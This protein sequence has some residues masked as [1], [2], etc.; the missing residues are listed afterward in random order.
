MALL[1]GTTSYEDLADVDLV[2][3]AVFEKNGS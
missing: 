2:I 1:T 3:E